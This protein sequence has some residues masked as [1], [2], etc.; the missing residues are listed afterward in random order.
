MCHFRSSASP[1]AKPSSNFSTPSQNLLS[2]PQS[3]GCYPLQ[4][5]TVSGQG[6]E[7]TSTSEGA[8]HTD[9]LSTM[10]NLVKSQSDS[11]ASA[12]HQHRKKTTNNYVNKGKHDDMY[13]A[14][15]GDI[16]VLPNPSAD[17]ISAQVNTTDSD[18]VTLPYASE[19]DVFLKKR[20][21]DSDISILSKTSEGVAR[22]KSSM[23]PGLRVRQVSTGSDIVVLGS[24]EADL[25]S[26]TTGKE[27]LT[28]GEVEE[29]ESLS[30]C[31]SLT[32][33]TVHSMVCIYTL[34]PTF[35]S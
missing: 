4:P 14:S 23:T 6:E 18:I 21:T 32:H 33:T 17:N 5:D 7:S 15:D 34:P 27:Q 12:K 28:I 25:L 16:E 29:D 8:R 26:S 19:D 2:D 24:T 9:K 1:K 35:L 31:G 11:S 13:I 10:D 22:T 30:P 3:L 20:S